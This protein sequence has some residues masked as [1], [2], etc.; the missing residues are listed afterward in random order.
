[1]R[2]VALLFGRLFPL[3]HRSRVFFILLHRHE[4]F[5]GSV[6]EVQE[7]GGRYD[8]ISCFSVSKWIHLQHGDKGLQTLF[9]RAYDLL[10][11]DGCFI[12]EPQ[13]WKSYK[14]R[15]YL[16]EK[17]YQNFK[18]IKTRPVQFPDY[19]KNQIGFSIVE[20]LGVPEGAP[21]GFDRCVYACWKGMRTEAE[22]G[23]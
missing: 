2:I 14:R 3:I 6:A 1:M 12:L 23:K 11:D 19:L 16:S 10:R 21:K 9:R 15:K 22:R 4:D 17:M 20:N 5:V 13:P 7:A 18:E 8:V